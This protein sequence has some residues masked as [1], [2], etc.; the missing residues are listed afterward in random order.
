MIKTGTRLRR[1]AWRHGEV[2]ATRDERRRPAG[3]QRR[4]RER[5]T[6]TLTLHVRIWSRSKCDGHF[7]PIGRPGEL[8][9]PGLAFTDFSLAEPTVVS[10]HAV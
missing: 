9:A 7:Y 1:T 4:R 2:R 8:S 6:P 3:D 10:V 5:P